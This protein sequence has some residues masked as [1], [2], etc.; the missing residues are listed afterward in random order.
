MREPILKEKDK[1]RKERSHSGSWWQKKCDRLMQD[2]QRER[3][4]SCEVCG[5]KNEV[6]HHY[7]TKS[8][9]SYLRYDWRNFIPLCHSCHFKHHNKSDP[10][11]HNTINAKRGAE[12]IEALEKDR[13]KPKKMGIRDYKLCE[14]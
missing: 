9:S 8:N 11:I 5:G 4:K 7:H 1:P 13:R 12:W 2:I 14:E 3:I 6:G 10:H